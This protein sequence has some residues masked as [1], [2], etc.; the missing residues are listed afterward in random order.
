MN[1]NFLNLYDSNLPYIDELK[2]AALRVIES[3]RYLDGEETST[4][5]K[6]IAEY[7]GSSNAIAVSNGLDAIR[8]I[9]RALIEEGRLSEGDEIL[10]P[11]NT[12]IASVLPLSELGLLPKPVPV[13]PHTHN[14]DFNR[15]R[16]FISPQTKGILLVHLYGSPCWDMP[17]LSELKE[18]GLL[19]IEDNAQAFGAESCE[20]GFHG[21]SKCGALADAAAISFYPTK[22]LGALGDAGM[23]VTSDS[24]LASDVRTLARYG[25]DRR[26]HHIYRGYNNRMDELQAAFLRVKL[27]HIDKENY[28]RA[29]IAGIYGAKIN[30]PDV[31]TPEIFKDGRQVWHQY[32]ITSSRRDELKEFLRK[33]GIDTDIH[34]PVPPQSQPCYKDFFSG[35][36]RGEAEHLANSI[37]S[38]P[39][40]NINPE[41]ALKISEKINEFPI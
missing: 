23:V 37:L 9:F 34:Y 11:S 32:V 18:R 15:V 27:P 10:F 41:D 31:T 25:S 33:N 40:A 8:L 14:L 35:E 12:F 2:Q 29:E 19:I 39:I 3:G 21:S 24:R 36:I 38:L 17:L 16:N 13:N 4:L 26:Y 6:E 20:P 30:H 5:E 28:R 1:Y 22:N 7:L